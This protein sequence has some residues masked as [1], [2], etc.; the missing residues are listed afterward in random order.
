MRLALMQPYFLPYVGYFQLIGAVDEFIIYDRIK[1][2]KKGWIN[3]NR[4]LRNGEDVMFSIPLKAASDQSTIVQRELADA[5]DRS[6]L[7]KQFEGAYRRAPFFVQ[8]FPLVQQIVS[9]DASNLFTYLHHSLVSVCRHLG[10]TTKIRVSSTIEIDSSLKNQE[11]VLAFCEAAGARTYVNA[12][13]GVELYSRDAFKARG[14]DL[15][16]IRAKPFEYAQFGQP[17]VPWLSIL[18]VLMFNS[19]AAT[20]DCIRSNYDLI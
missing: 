19:L 3:R 17:F 2:T 8:T 15:Q 10:L 16:F 12:I 4:M 7:L 1:Y 5:F 6:S 18:D 14:I 20:Q 9:H 13:G 11:M